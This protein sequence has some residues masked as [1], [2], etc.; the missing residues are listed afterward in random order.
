MWIERNTS[1]GCFQQVYAFQIKVNGDIFAP[2][3]F[4]HF[5][6][7]YAFDLCFPMLGWSNCVLRDVLWMHIFMDAMRKCILVS[8]A[9]I[10]FFFS[11]HLTFEGSFIRLF[12]RKR[13]SHYHFP[14]PFSF[15]YPISHSNEIANHFAQRH[16]AFIMTAISL[17][18]F[19]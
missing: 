9:H 10:L 4:P 17:Y 18:C 14:S 13:T 1:S 7:M 12:Q 6:Y 16:K 8:H 15:A 3:H 2:I 5:P 11:L 19:L